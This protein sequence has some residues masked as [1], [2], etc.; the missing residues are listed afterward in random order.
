MDKESRIIS[1]FSHALNGDDGALFGDF[2]YSK[3][4]FI[5]GVHFKREWLSMR[6]IG[7][8]A[9]LVN[10]SDAIAMNATP[11]YALLGLALPK[12]L[13]NDE[14]NALCAGIKTECDR[15]GVG[16][17]GGDTTSG[18]KITISLT[19]ISRPEGKVLFRKR[20]K[21]GDFIAFTGTLG[22]SLKGL[23]ILQ[24]G[25]KIAG[26][27][28]FARPELRAEFMKKSAKILKS[29]MDISDGLANDLP[30]LLGK[31]GA[32]ISAKISKNQWLSGEE[33]ELL[34]AFAPKNKNRVFSLAKQTRT[35]L[36][37][38]GQVKNEHLKIP[39]YRA[40]KHF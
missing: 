20:A 35:K 21:K 14:I 40:F 6:Q 17:I 7:A 4:L 33:Y 27:S 34:I 19:I 37:I 13:G 28:R 2:V 30:K 22:Q 11:L 16:V 10:I 9:V 32:K 29:A 15:W 24:N 25:G 39:K 38:I 1:H 12:S 8:K 26:N 36:T 3:D 31:K 18:E 23:K 5:E